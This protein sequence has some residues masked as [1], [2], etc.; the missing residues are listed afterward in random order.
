[1]FVSSEHTWEY[2]IAKWEFI[3]HLECQELVDISVL[4][5]LKVISSE[6]PHWWLLDCTHIHTPGSL[7]H[8]AGSAGWAPTLRPL[9]ELN[10]M[11]FYY[12]V[13]IW[14]TGCSEALCFY[15]T[16]LVKQV[17]DGAFALY[18]LS[19][20]SWCWVHHE[21]TQQPAPDQAWMMGDR[22]WARSPSLPFFF[23][24]LPWK[25]THKLSKHVVQKI[26]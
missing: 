25:V 17:L 14:E 7:T 8:G 9:F 1:M 12:S 2:R 23:H 26:W 21:I 16:I 22:S 5:F 13:I 15:F 11:T 19:E 18:S 20:E 10:I 24:S 4:D 3:T 6:A